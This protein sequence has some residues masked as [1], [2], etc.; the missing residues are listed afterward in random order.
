MNRYSDYTPSV[1]TPQSMEELAF[2]PLMKRKKHDD[3][4][5]KQQ[6]IISGLAKVDPSNKYFNEAIR[7]KNELE[8]KIDITANELA[9]NG[10]NNDMIGK[11]ISLNRQYQDL[12]SP[13]GKIGQINA[14]K[15]NT[16]KLYK[17]Y[18]D[19]AIKMGQSQASAEYWAKEALAKHNDVK[20]VPLYDENG[21]VI[22]F[23]IDKSPVKY[24][25]LAELTHNVG[26]EAGMTS[27]EWEKSRGAMSLN[28][29]GR[30]VINTQK[31]GL[32]ADNIKQL[33]KA[34]DYLNLRIDSQNDSLR[35]SLDYNR[36]DPLEAKKQVA[37]QLGIYVKNTTSSKD[38]ESIGSV[39]WNNND[40]KTEDSIYND[41]IQ[42]P[43]SIQ[44]LDKDIQDIDFTE[45]GTIPTGFS[46]AMSQSREGL[47]FGHG[48]I[49]KN[50]NEP[51]TYKHILNPLQQKFYETAS[52]RLIANGKLPKN[53]N[54]NDPKNASI[55]GFYMKN[56]MK[57]PTVANDIIRADVA[58]DNQ[59]FTGPLASKDQNSR[60]ATLEQDVRGDD[61][62]RTM[63]DVKTGE[64]IKLEEGDK[65]DYLGVDSPINYRN[66]NFQNNKAQS[67]MGHRA[68]VLDKNGNVKAN[69]VVSR[70]DNEMSDQNFKN[71]Y[72]INQIYKNAIDNMGTYVRPKG[73]FSNNKNLTKVIIKVND[74]GS[75]QIKRDGSDKPSRPLSNEEFLLQMDK[76]ANEK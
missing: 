20:Q 27:D 34:A 39:D 16:A 40:S 26:K 68:H 53:A 76:I 2:V 60:N 18:V 17:E 56:H 57:F 59:L 6:D 29:Q 1:Y 22:D 54:L 44:N 43:S 70:T 61:P 19:D 7:L 45:I 46:Y 65:I 31:G 64:K 24:Y 69:V 41:S 63:I 12:V 9:T 35:Q 67:V 42:D 5:A 55:I 21:R 36:I 49:S 62:L 25:D 33:Q 32:T 28:D 4:L 73:K 66:Y 52:K 38:N 10:F 48:N 50:P 74:D 11:T 75:F 37:N 71:M 14:E 51:Y 15:I 3:I 13:T 30:F 47:K 58:I 8:S 72:D 23:K